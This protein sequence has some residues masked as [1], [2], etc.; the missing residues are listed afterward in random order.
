MKFGNDT[1]FDSDWLSALSDSDFTI[2]HTRSIS[3]PDY[4]T[5]LMKY[6]YTMTFSANSGIYIAA[7]RTTSGAANVDID[8]YQIFPRPCVRMV[9]NSAVATTGARYTS[10][11]HRWRAISSAN[12]M[13]TEL[14]E[15][16]GDRVELE[17][18]KVNTL[19]SLIG[20]ETSAAAA[21][22]AATLTYNFIYVIPRWEL[23]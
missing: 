23:L 21:T 18:G 2:R 8:F 22:I 13:T 20:D 6:G 10:K 16:R 9:H 19:I 4:R 1:P 14:V 3:I 11:D 12:L 15:T 17:P 5:L 7:G